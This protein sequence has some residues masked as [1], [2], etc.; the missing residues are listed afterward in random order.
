MIEVI[1][2]KG[3][4]S[5]KSYMVLERAMQHWTR[6][7]TAFISDSFEVLWPECK[8]FAL[9]HH[10]LY[11]EDDQYHAVSSE[12]IHR[13]HEV[14]P[15]GSEDCP[16][17]IVVDEAQDQIDVRDYANKSKKDLF[18]WCCQSRHD[19]NDLVFVSQSA[20]N[21]DARIRRLATFTWSS[22]NSKYYTIRSFGNLQKLIQF[23]TLGFNDG[24]YF[25]RAQLDYDGKTVLDSQWVKANKGLLGCYKSKSMRQARK[26]LG[27]AVKKKELAKEKGRPMFKWIIVG[28][29]AL[30]IYSCVQ[31][32]KTPLMPGPGSPAKI[33]ATQAPET[34]EHAPKVESYSIE[35]IPWRSRGNNWIRTQSGVFK[36]GRMSPLGLVEVIADGVIRVRKPDGTLVYIVT[37]SDPPTPATVTATPSPIAAATPASIVVATDGTSD[38]DKDPR[39]S[40]ATAPTPLPTPKVDKAKQA[41]LR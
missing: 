18:S 20:K 36:V 41:V 26:R 7:G 10:G 39:W 6:G 12:E 33:S 11:I 13:L 19:D 1:E 3:V 32:R 40:G 2:G 34:V 22:R 28:A 23:G 35:N 8:A 21:L 38:R 5:G 14:T 16:V 37:D 31:L 30:G 4:G 9:K 17:L 27:G 15:P 25:I 29:V 24:F